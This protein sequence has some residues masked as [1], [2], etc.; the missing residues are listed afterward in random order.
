MTHF[1]CLSC[2]VCGPLGYPS[3]GVLD[4]FVCLGGLILSFVELVGRWGD[5]ET[6]HEPLSQDVE[7][8]EA[9]NVTEAMATF[10][11]L[12]CCC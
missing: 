4:L 5:D 2:E 1:L 3:G 9:V 10:Q 11:V 6:R 7:M 8:E 12:H